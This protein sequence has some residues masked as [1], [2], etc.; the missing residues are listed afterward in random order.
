MRIKR[1]LKNLFD[2]NMEREL[3]N[4]VQAING[5]DVDVEKLKKDFEELKKRIETLELKSNGN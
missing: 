3:D 2:K 5:Q 4:V 1:L